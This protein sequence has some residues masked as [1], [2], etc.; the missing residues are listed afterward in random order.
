MMSVVGGSHLLDEVRVGRG[1]EAGP[2]PLPAPAP[3]TRGDPH[4]APG[5]QHVSRQ[6]RQAGDS[7]SVSIIMTTRADKE[8]SQFLQCVCRQRL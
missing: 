6:R 5:H 2:R 1:V 8:T 7:R 3:R 4:P